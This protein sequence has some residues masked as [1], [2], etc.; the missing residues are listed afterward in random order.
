MLRA[1]SDYE[2]VICPSKGWLNV[3]VVGLWKYR[4]L[5]GVLVHRGA[6]DDE[7]TFA[8][9]AAPSAAAIAADPQPKDVVFVFD[10]SGSMAD[11]DKIG[12]A[13]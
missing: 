1:P 7:G 3:D 10:T 13:P 12:Q 6:G 5:L 9:F 2:T 4:D 11:G 8:L